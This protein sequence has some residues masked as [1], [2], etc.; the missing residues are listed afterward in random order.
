[1][2]N[3]NITPGI[4]D[5]EFIRG[6]V[7]MTKEEIRTLSIAKLRLQPGDRF[8]DIGAGTGSV[9]IEAALLLP[10]QTVYAVEHNLEAVSLIAQNCEK[11]G[12]GNIQIIAGKAPEI[13]AEVPPVNKV[14]IGGSSGNLPEILEWITAQAK[15]DLTIVINAITLETLMTAQEWFSG[16]DDF[17]I[18]LSQVAITRFE[19]VGKYSMMKP[20]TPVFIFVARRKQSV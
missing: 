11:F 19:S 5:H 16:S 15:D 1:M 20:L 7:P 4:P 8:L 18:E 13:L 9:S 17:D 6:K 12:V 3:K 10:E 2:S 14:F